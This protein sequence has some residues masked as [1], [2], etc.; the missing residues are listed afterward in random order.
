MFPQKKKPAFQRAF[1]PGWIPPYWNTN[2]VFNP[3]LAAQQRP[4]SDSNMC[5]SESSSMPASAQSRIFKPSTMVFLLKLFNLSL[6]IPPAGFGAH[7]QG[8][9]QPARAWVLC[10]YLMVCLLPEKGLQG[11]QRLDYYCLIQ[12]EKYINHHLLQ[13][14]IN[15]IQADA[16]G[17]LWLTSSF[18][19]L[20][21][22]GIDTRI[23]LKK[24]TPALST[25]RHKALFRRRDRPGILLMNAYG[26]L[27]SL[28]K[29]GMMQQLNPSPDSVFIGYAGQAWKINRHDWQLPAFLKADMVVDEIG[30]DGRLDAFRV[31]T[32]WY[33]APDKKNKGSHAVKAV[34]GAYRMECNNR[35]FTLTGPFGI[36][37]EP[38][39]SNPYFL[40]FSDTLVLFGSG[41]NLFHCDLRHG[42]LQVINQ[43]R[44]YSKKEI[45]CAYP[46]GTNDF[47]LGTYDNGLLRLSITPAS[48]LTGKHLNLEKNLFVYSYGMYNDGELLIPLDGVLRMDTAERNEQR[49]T[50]STTIGHPMFIDSRGIAW[51]HDNAGLIACQLDRNIVRLIPMVNDRIDLFF[52][53]LGIVYCTSGN[54]I[55]QVDY[56]K[57]SLR[58]ITRIN[59]ALSFFNM[60]R[61]GENFW[62]LSQNGAY[63]MNGQFQILRHILQNVEV[64]DAVQIGKTWVWATYGRGVLKGL[65]PEPVQ[66][67]FSDPYDWSLASTSLRY[68]PVLERLW[69]VCNK[70]IFIL[71][72]DRNANIGGFKAKL[73]C[74]RQLPARE[75]NGGIYPHESINRHAHYYFASSQGLLKIPRNIET[76]FS[77]QHLSLI[78]VVN[79]KDT[80]AET[81]QTV[82]PTDHG[83]FSM[84][85]KIQRPFA[86][87]REL[88]YRISPTMAEWRPVPDNM[89]LGPMK[90]P[91]GNY[92][93]EIR[94]MNGLLKSMEIEVPPY[95]YNTLW[96]RIIFIACT[97]L[98][99]L[100]WLKLRTR[101]S[102][103]RENQL[104][105]EVNQRTHELRTTLLDLETSR[106]EL[107]EAYETREKMNAVL[108]H[109]IRSPLMF[110][111]E[112]AYVFNRRLKA[113]APQYYPTFNLFAGTI[114]DL[115]ILATD[116]NLWM[117]RPLNDGQPLRKI[118]VADL[119][120]NVVRFYEP[121]IESGTNTLH[122][123]I[124]PEIATLQ[125]ETHPGILNSIIR[126]L[127]DNSN[128]Y[129][130]GGEIRLKASLKTETL[131]IEVRDSGNGLPAEIIRI[132]GRPGKQ[133][134]E[135]AL[136]ETSADEIGLNL[137]LR[138]TRMLG[139]RL[140]YRHDANGSWFR[141]E[142]PLRN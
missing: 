37:S 36:L 127:L 67:L 97:A 55:Y 19:L 76:L 59:G 104:T 7:A 35:K 66:V 52:E 95:W 21:S 13:N 65:N 123:E 78:P 87:M 28:S 50:N 131:L 74:G 84:R 96:F 42:T 121:I 73:E 112:S 6:R 133:D 110:L 1:A 33:F 25:D 70:A 142:L 29:G 135:C 98:L 22:D 34:C 91:P 83:Y 2:P 126:N 12:P 47:M 90:L 30:Y 140:F 54:S 88:S 129:T 20:N 82:L 113:E 136:Q 32:S 18:G 107:T 63:L 44:P 10:V 68:D 130:S 116:F 101:Q 4:Y 53:T 56:E 5:N 93:L 49:L 11:Q 62:L 109:D 124:L 92:R 41:N 99:A 64:R 16:D 117:K 81:A 27:T 77:D 24:N 69:L 46:I 51:T 3:S 141:L 17:T 128:K 80:M 9:C 48:L 108:L 58:L 15:G 138:F 31:G 118:V 139:G 134:G 23:Y 86:Y 14:S 38:I 115:Y 40:W 100:L 71:T 75:L 103:K 120:D 132:Y 105:Y 61:D 106:R 72:C 111:T 57:K 45:Y 122:T 102:V 39:D 85:I 114:K 43:L 26:G 79:G 89:L 60:R 8:V 137:I 94:N 125:I 119:V